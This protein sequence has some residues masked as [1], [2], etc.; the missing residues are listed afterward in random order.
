MAPSPTGSPHVGLARTALFN[1]AFARHHGGTFVFRIEDTDA[2]R[3]TQESYDA[4]LEVMRWLGLD[5]DE[6]PRGRRPVRALPAVRARRPLPRRPGPA[7]RES[8]YT[9]DCYCTTEEVDARRKASGSK[10]MGYDGFCRELT[11]EQV[12]AFE[13][14]GR[15][16]V[17]R[18]RMPDGEI[19]CDD[20]VRGEIT[21]QTEFVPDFALVPRQRR[22][23]LHAGQPGRRRADGDHPRAARRGPALQHAAPDR[24]ARGA[25]SSSASRSA[26]PAVRPPALRHGRGQQEALQAR[27]R[28]APARLPRRRASCPRGCSTTS[29]CSAGRSP[30]T[31]TCSR[32]R[33]WSRRST[34]ATSTPTRRASTS[35]RPRRS[36]PPTCG[37]SPLEDMTERVLPFLQRGRRGRPTR[38]PT[39]TRSC[40]TLAMPL[41]AER[42]NKLTEAP[43]CSASCSS[44]RTSFAR[45][46]GRR[47]E[48]ARRRRPRRRRRRRTTRSTALRRLVDGGDRGGAA[49]RARRGARAQAAQRVRAGAGGGHRPPGLAAAV[50][51]AGAARPR[52]QPGAGSQSALAVSRSPT[53]RAPVP[54]PPP[55]ARR[56]HLRRCAGAAGAGPVASRC[57][58]AVSRRW[59]SAA[60]TLILRASLAGAGGRRV[61]LHR[62]IVA[63]LRPGRTRSTAGRATPDCVDLDDPTPL[64]LAY[65]NLVLASAIPLTWL[66]IRVLHG[67]RPRWLSSVRAADAVALPRSSASGWRSSR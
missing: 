55:P 10:V 46:A 26:R 39:P 51:V 67:L 45:D 65:L 22:P 25:A 4:L 59:R 21:F 49:G 62:V 9:Y 56:Y 61:S 2:A 23:A 42:I 41:V 27:P 16:P 34:S 7:A 31:A 8:K 36:T 32:S 13:A 14:E 66:I 64:G 63:R 20:L 44:T 52:A 3:N 57:L 18:F 47:R 11:D 48:G 30:P 17:V 12:A 29:P 38:S 28:G 40:S 54:A 19:T 60:G 6:G 53:P 43:D 37:C 24:A 15:A 1:W 58:G 33:R 35:R 50:R 5:W